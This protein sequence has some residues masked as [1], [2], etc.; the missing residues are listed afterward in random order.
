M[1]DD[2]PQDDIELY[3]VDEDTGETEPLLTKAVPAAEPRGMEEVQPAVED[4]TSDEMA[5]EEL[6]HLQALQKETDAL[7]EAYWHEAKFEPF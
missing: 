6:G 7:K 5:Q 2:N 4:A 3:I 1:N